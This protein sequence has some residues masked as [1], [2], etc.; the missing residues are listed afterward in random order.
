[1]ADVLRA[2]GV[3]PRGASLVDGS[4]LPGNFITAETGVALMRAFAARPDAERW[5]LAQPILGVDGSVAAVAADTPAKGHVY[6]KTGT[7]GDA[8]LLNGRLRLE[9]KALSG[10]IDA[11]SGR[12]LAF[13]LMV[14]QGMFDDIQGVFAAN[15][16]LGHIAAEIWAAY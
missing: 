8:D 12:Q 3:D 7:L 11:K 13:T 5:K 15:N 1:M 4:G 6:A 2:A 10:Y 9:A 16:D 14:N